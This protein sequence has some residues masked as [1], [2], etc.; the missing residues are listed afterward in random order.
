MIRMPAGVVTIFLLSSCVCQSGSAASN[1][2]AGVQAIGTSILP[3]AGISQAGVIDLRA[4][5][6]RASVV[7]PSG[8]YIILAN[9]DRRGRIVKVDL[10]FSPPKRVDD[11]LLGFDESASKVAVIDPDG[12]FAYFALSGSIPR[13]VKIRT[14]DLTRVATLNL[15][16]TDGLILSGAI[17]PDGGYAYFGTSLSPGRVVKI[18]LATFTRANTLNLS[19]GENAASSM[20]MDSAGNFAYVGTSSFPARVVK[21]NLSTFTRESAIV[22]P[23][24]EFGLSVALVDPADTF[25]YFGC[26]V[27]PAAIIKIRLTRRASSPIL[28]SMIIQMAVRSL[29]KFLSPVLLSS[30]NYC[31]EP[32]KMP[33]LKRGRL[34]P[35]VFLPILESRGPMQDC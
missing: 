27:Y 14:S 25:L 21:I 6:P 12:V 33:I 34:E 22:L 10:N 8:D 13:I 19:L 32:I 29:R 20:A 28:G 30:M 9:G 5:Y 31:W 16:A 11:L 3:N 4:E 1:F 15:Q 7:D 17:D 2:I 26:T 23:A 35:T 18:N 24:G